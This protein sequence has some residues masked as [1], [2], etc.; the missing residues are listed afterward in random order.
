[1][2]VMRETDR[3]CAELLDDPRIVIVILPRQR[4]ALV[5]LVLVTAD[6]AQRRRNT[7]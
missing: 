2:L 1:M 5:E 3:V 6:T 7:V 4:I